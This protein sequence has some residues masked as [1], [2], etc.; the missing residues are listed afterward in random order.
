MSEAAAKVD[1]ETLAIRSRPPR[2]IRFKRGVIIAIA[3]I[4]S[5]SLIA[6]TWMALRPHIARPADSRQELTEP[7]MRAGAEALDGTPATYG[8]VPRLGPPLPGDRGKPIVER[9]RQ[10]GA[11]GGTGG[12][13]DRQAD[14]AEHERQVSALRAARESGLLV[15]SHQTAQSAGLS[16]PPT[17]ASAT[18]AGADKLSLDPDRD[19]NGQQ[20]KSDFVA[21]ADGGGDINPHAVVAAASPYMLSAGSVISASLITGLRSDLPGL[22]T[23]QVTERVYDSATGRILLIPQGARLVGTY[24][25]VIAFGQRRAL[26]VWQRILFPDGSSLRL[27][28]APATDPAGYAGLAD[29]V[30][31]HTWELL[32]G[33]VLSTMLG[34]GAQLQFSGDSDLVEALRQSTQQSVSQAGSQITARTLQI[35]PTITIRPGAPVRLMVH[36][37]LILKPWQENG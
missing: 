35:Q 36:H 19:P 1:P 8:D 14:A 5:V 2:A 6:V 34:V 20:R 28:N 22:V 30:D 18:S 24:D 25:S 15:Q 37:D 29:R 31:F 4:G 16:E 21:K 3:A 9:Q 13:T 10:L 7:D 32:K 12:S 27:D 33:V 17:A 26:V 23:A 11:E